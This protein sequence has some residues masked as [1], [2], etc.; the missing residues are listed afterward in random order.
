MWLTTSL[1]PC[2]FLVTTSLLPSYYFVTSSYLLLGKA[3]GYGSQRHTA[4][5]VI[6]RKLL[7]YTGLHNGKKWSES[8]RLPEGI[9]LLQLISM[10]GFS[11]VNP[12]LRISSGMC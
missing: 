3:L 2:Y 12:P 4:R 11:S 7:S 10:T 5:Q 8:L 6:R 1:L 9:H